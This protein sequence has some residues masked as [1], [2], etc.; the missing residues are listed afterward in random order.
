M[1]KLLATL[2]VICGALPGVV[3]ADWSGTVRADQDGD[4]RATASEP[5]LEGVAVS[6]GREVVRTDADGR[7]TLP[8]RPGVF[9]KLTCPDDYACPQWYSLDGGD[10]ALRPA[11]AADDFFFIQLSDAHVMAEI[12]DFTRFS[13]PPIPWWLPQFA[14]DWLTLRFLDRGYAELTSDDIVNALREAVSPYSDVS[15][16][17]ETGVFRAYSEELGRPGSP[18]G[19]V[20][21]QIREAFAEVGRL[22]PDF[23]I[24]TGDLWLESNTATPEAVESWVAV[25]R[26]A[27]ETAGVPFFNTIGNNEIAGFMNDEFS[28]SDPRYGKHYFRATYGPTAYSFDRG[29][30][31]FVALD[32]HR[33]DPTEDEPKAWDFNSMEPAIRDWVDADLAAHEGRGRVLVALNHEPFHIDERWGYDDPYKADD[34]GLFARH[35]VAYS[36]AGHTHRNGYDDGEATTHIT[37]G[38]ISGL[39]W[40]LPVAIHARGYRLF[41]AKDG[42]LYS[43]WKNTDQPVLGFVTPVDPAAV[44]ELHP[45]SKSPADKDALV[46]E[47]RIVVV[48]SDAK[49][50]FAEL[51]LRLDGQPLSLERWGDYFAAATLDADAIPAEG[52]TLELRARGSDQAD[53]SSSLRVGRP[54]NLA[55]GVALE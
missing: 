9:V 10:F 12:A 47:V 28:A 29:P 25:Y 6:N 52:A 11:P 37:T 5:P 42:R 53:H 15:G 30:F 34:E 1:L 19:D 14:A 41:Y 50:P 16:L 23:V 27:S 39:R 45:G 31:H 33:P 54:A 8:E 17:S 7:Y 38:A 48:A 4:G 3:A 18:L 20:R 26:E 40:T 36:L 35:G 21:R 24:S 51:S 43:A 44:P 49:S 55:P 13:S 22:E 2:A 32:T 46:G